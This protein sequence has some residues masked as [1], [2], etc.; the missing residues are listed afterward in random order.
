MKKDR[1][2]KNNKQS[3][4]KQQRGEGEAVEKSEIIDCI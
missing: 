4:E 1:E 3:E 2:R